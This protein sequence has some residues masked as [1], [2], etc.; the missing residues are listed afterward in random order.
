LSAKPVY[1]KGERKM[2]SAHT[3]PERSFYAKNYSSMQKQFGVAGYIAG[4]APG[5]DDRAVN[6]IQICL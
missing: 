2:L 5:R 4:S 6:G 1:L 3:L